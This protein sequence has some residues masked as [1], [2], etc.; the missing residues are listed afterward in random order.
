MAWVLDRIADGTYKPGQPVLS[1]RELART[2]DCCWRTGQSA[3]NDL[4]ATGV[5]THGITPHAR[6]RVADPEPR[7]SLP[8]AIRELCRTLTALRLEAGL[9]Q[10]ELAELI[11]CSRASVGHA[12]TG[13]L[14]QSRNWWHL[15]DKALHANGELL[16]LHDEY[17]IA[18]MNTDD[19]P[20][21]PPPDE[22]N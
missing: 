16:R 6:Y 21:S 10:P 7:K 19:P 13:R 12:E 5:L 17:L 4:I 20:P 15:A 22:D 1:G 8:D 2:A 18:Q 9:T 14:S 11:G 3:L